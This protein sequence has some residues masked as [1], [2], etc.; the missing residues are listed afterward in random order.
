MFKWTSFNKLY[1]FHARSRSTGKVTKA[2][3]SISMYITI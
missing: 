3:A 1:T 2:N